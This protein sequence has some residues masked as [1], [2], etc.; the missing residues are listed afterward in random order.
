ML[1][2]MRRIEDYLPWAQAFV[3]ARRVVAVQVNPERG[4]YKALSENGTSY[5]LER[6][7]QAQALLRVLEQRQMGTD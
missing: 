6:L 4:E 7:E 3:E 2:G 1:G 5:F